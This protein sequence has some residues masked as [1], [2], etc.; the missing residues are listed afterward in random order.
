MRYCFAISQSPH[1]L[2]VA[3]S[4][5]S[6]SPIVCSSERDPRGS[7]GKTLLAVVRPFTRA[8]RAAP[9][10]FFRHHETPFVSRQ[11]PTKAS[12]ITTPWSG[13]GN[14]LIAMDIPRSLS[15]RVNHDARGLAYPIQ[16]K[17]PQTDCQHT[18]NER[19]ANYSRSSEVA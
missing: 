14:G 10:P 3:D 1:T 15:G 4:T 8:T 16:P 2:Q 9:I 19:A 12:K 5:A 18:V 11:T 6:A 17:Y 7:I 13:G